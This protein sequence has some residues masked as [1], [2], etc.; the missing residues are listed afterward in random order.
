MEGYVGAC[1]L[2]APKS[3]PPAVILACGGHM[4]SS[5]HRICS[6]G[7]IVLDADAVRG[8]VYSSASLLLV[9]VDVLLMV[10]SG[11]GLCLIMMPSRLV[12][13]QTKLMSFSN[14]S[15]Q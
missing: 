3:A 15:L 11:E 12:R 8:D 9:A 7:L 5:G 13:L 4:A 10:M 1:W 14:S 2:A 6:S